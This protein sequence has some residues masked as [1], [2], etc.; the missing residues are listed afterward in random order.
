MEKICIV[1]LRKHFTNHMEDL[2]LRRQG[3]RMDERGI[4]ITP[5]ASGSEDQRSQEPQAGDGVANGR[6]DP[7]G[8]RVSLTLTRDQIR[9]L[10]F[11]PHT[12][13]LLHEK[14]LEVSGRVGHGDEGMTIQLELP[15]LPPVRLLKLDVVTRMLQISRSCLHRILTEGKLKSYK[16]GRLRRVMLDDVLSY[17]QSQQEWP[18]ITTT[19]RKNK[20]ITK[21]DS[22]TVFDQGG[23]RDVL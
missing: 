11:D 21:R 3:E 13:S 22:A 20:D 16:I 7:A 9:T 17:L 12:A 6:R 14:T 5:P 1:K 4:F 15:S 10:Q 19:D 18:S 23:L 8:K 2:H